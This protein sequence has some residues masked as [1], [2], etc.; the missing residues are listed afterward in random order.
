[1]ILSK[2]LG[3]IFLTRPL[4]N[5][6]SFASQLLRNLYEVSDP[7]GIGVV[8]FQKVNGKIQY[9]VFTACAHSKSEH[10]YST[11]KHELLAIV[12]PLR[13]FHQFLWRS[14]SGLYAE[15]KSL[16]YLHTRKL[17]HSIMIN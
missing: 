5:N 3:G 1:M 9:V 16:T 2:N 4:F 13:K 11:D 14:P 10:N 15:H 6:K 17:F 8:L 7:S 12:F